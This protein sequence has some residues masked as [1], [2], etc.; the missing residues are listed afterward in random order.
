[1][2]REQVNKISLRRSQEAPPSSFWHRKQRFRP[3]CLYS[4]RERGG[5]KIS[6]QLAMIRLALRRAR[7]KKVTQDA[8]P[9]SYIFISSAR[10][11]G[12]RQDVKRLI[13]SFLHWRSAARN[14]LE[15]TH[16][17]E[18]VHG[19]RADWKASYPPTPLGADRRTH[20]KTTI[21]SEVGGWDGPFLFAFDQ[22]GRLA[23]AGELLAARTPVLTQQKIR[24]DLW[25]QPIYCVL[26]KCVEVN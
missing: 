5:T 12:G 6:H 22:S 26:R 10:R 13:T 1:M 20:T 7:S 15:R 11:G 4:V 9:G 16:F 8:W 25:F 24:A 18:R 21:E 19:A 14:R 3:K 17:A 23:V 2:R